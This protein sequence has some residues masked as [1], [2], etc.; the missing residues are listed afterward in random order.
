MHGVVETYFDTAVVITVLVILGQVLEL[1]ARSQTSTAITDAPITK[2]RM[3][4][5]MSRGRR[6]TLWAGCSAMSVAAGSVFAR[7]EAISSSAFGKGELPL[8]RLNRS[9]S[10]AA[11]LGRSK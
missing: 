5:Y 2:R 7:S 9:R 6:E 4:A 11:L 8:A 3:A 10:T 1:R